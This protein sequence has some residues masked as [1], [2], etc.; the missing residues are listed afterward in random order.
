MP[1]SSVAAGSRAPPPALPSQ[2]NYTVFVE[3]RRRTALKLFTQMPAE[4]RNALQLKA[5]N[6][7]AVRKGDF[8]RKRL[9]VRQMRQQVRARDVVRF[10]D[11]VHSLPWG[12]GGCA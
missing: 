8:I 10:G 3:V 11:A 1:L 7:E 6:K 5:S 9:M 2:R 4:A 12:R